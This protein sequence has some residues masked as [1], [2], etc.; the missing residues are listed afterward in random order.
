MCH[1]KVT[2]I[3]CVT[4]MFMVPNWKF[5]CDLEIGW[6][7][8][9]NNKAHLP[10]YF[11][12]YASFCNHPW[13][14]TGVAAQKCPIRVKISNFLS[15]VTLK[16]EGWLWNN[17][18]ATLLCYFKLCALFRSQQWIQIRV[19]SQKMLI[20]GQNQRFFGP[21]WTKN[22]TDDLEKE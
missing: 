13:I 5:L 11:K 8:L 2:K 10:C 3:F 14:Q 22:L 12:L 1:N 18:R 6:M 20:S 21:I 19:K 9:Q 15:C 17:D 4:S 16:F 7:I